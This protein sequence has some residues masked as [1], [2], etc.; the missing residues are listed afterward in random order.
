MIEKKKPTKEAEGEKAKRTKHPES[1]K[2]KGRLKVSPSLPPP[3]ANFHYC[4]L[5]YGTVPSCSMRCNWAGTRYTHP[6]GTW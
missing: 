2:R 5:F 6:K 1:K 3:Q 4:L